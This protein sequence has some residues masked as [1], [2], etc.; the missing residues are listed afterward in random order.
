[1]IEYIAIVLAGLTGYALGKQAYLEEQA[2]IVEMIQP[3][4]KIFKTKQMIKVIEKRVPV[5]QTQ[6]VIEKLAETHGENS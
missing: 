4:I 1:M 3:A 5:E 6:G 2:K